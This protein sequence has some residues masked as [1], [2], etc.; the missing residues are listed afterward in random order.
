MRIKYNSSMK[1]M[2]ETIEWQIQEELILLRVVE[3]KV[4]ISLGM[5]SRRKVKCK[6][7]LVRNEVLQSELYC[8]QLSH[9]SI[10]DTAD[11]F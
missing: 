2:I 6:S 11:I 4:K 9:G 3:G 1:L 10:Y 5:S 7:T 8:I